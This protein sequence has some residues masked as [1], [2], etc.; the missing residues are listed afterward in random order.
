[1]TTMRVA[2]L[3]AL[4]ATTAAWLTA[5]AG[6]SPPPQLYQLRAAA[7]VSAAPAVASTGMW[8][9][10]LPVRLPEYLD[11]DALLVP[12]GQAG[13]QALAGHRWAEP[14]R[15]SVPRLLRQDLA[16][17]LGESRVWSAPVP[18]GVAVTRQLRVEILALEATAERNAVM[19]Q[20]R[21]T[22]ADSN[23]GAAP[24]VDTVQLTV[25]SAAADVDSLV[26]AHRLA[27]WRLAEKIVATR[28]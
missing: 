27:L 13:L 16:T 21:W 11:R 19:L 12:Q 3:A 6:S 25:P 4:T 9:L 23:T 2:A 18:A 14:L 10:V 28:R 24:L 22:V 7:P 20:A 1:M 5:C 26:V 8:Q 15:D 17:L